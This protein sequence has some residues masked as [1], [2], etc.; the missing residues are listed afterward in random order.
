MNTIT[1]AWA[2]FTGMDSQAWVEHD[3][4]LYFANHNKVNKALT[5]RS[6][7][8]SVIDGK[9]K[10]AFN[11]LAPRTRLKHIQLT[12]PIITTNGESIQAQ[13]GFDV[14][15]K[16]KELSSILSTTG[17]SA[18][19]WDS[20][21]WDLARWSAADLTISDWRSVASSPGRCFA[22]RLRIL[23]KDVTF[24]LNAVDVLSAP[25]GPM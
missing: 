3:G 13:L 16:S 1:K 14:D 15:Y 11:Y 22:F 8:G 7:N 24:I 21:T 18:S 5:G 9:I 25:G 17:T 6:D 12:R 23:M 20:A 10:T 2:R 4:T 19:I